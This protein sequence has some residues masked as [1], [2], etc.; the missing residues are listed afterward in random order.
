MKE[1]LLS[2][3]WTLPVRITEGHSAI[4]SGEE[5]KL[6]IISISQSFPAIV[7]ERTDLRTLSLLAGVQ[8]FEM[9]A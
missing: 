9:W 8:I 1:L 7:F 4:S 5:V 2:P 6:V 3:G